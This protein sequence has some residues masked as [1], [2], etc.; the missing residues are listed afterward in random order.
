[1]VADHPLALD[2]ILVGSC[3][4]H[5]AS[6][7]VTDSA[8]AGTAIASGI[9]T[10][11]QMVGVDPGGAPHT[12]I[13]ERAHEHGLAT[14]LVVKS[15]MTD[16]TP[17]VFAAHVQNRGA[18]DTIAVQEIQHHVDVLLGGGRD[19]F[20]PLSRGGVRKDSLDV[21]AEARQKGYAYVAGPAELA[22]AAR[23]PLLGLFA[24]EDLAYAVDHD[25]AREPGLPEMAKK[26]VALLSKHKAGFFLMVEGSRVDHAGHANDP[27]TH[28][29]ELL[30]LH[31]RTYPV[32]WRW[33][34]GAVDAAILT[35]G[36]TTVFG[37]PLLVVALLGLLDSPL[38]LRRRFAQP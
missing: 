23:T 22:A 21:I 17:A 26:A 11:N 4:T 35:G 16:A 18:Q 27:A 6:S 37:W 29:R 33:S 20:L 31:R 5:S 32:F 36:I 2:G 12:T 10:K 13:L 34:Q 7:R 9:K 15:T 14:G 19:W 25:A 24:G 30:D 1:M 3:S 8:A 28:A 38:G